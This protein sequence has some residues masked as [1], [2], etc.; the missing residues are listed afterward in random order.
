[1][2]NGGEKGKTARLYFIECEKQAKLKA[3][4]TLREALLLAAQVEFE[5]EQLALKVDN[6]QT[7]LDIRLDWV[8]II[9]VAQHNRISEKKL[10]WHKLKRKSEDL[11][12]E[13]KRA[14]S[15]RY[16]YQNLY[17]VNV[18]KA[19]YPELRYDIKEE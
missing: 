14:A 19:A 9:K 2:L 8:S 13:I 7:V 1:M 15:P 18:F 10:D 3:P 6:L 16:K 4:K 17:H 11:G 12:Y 5:K